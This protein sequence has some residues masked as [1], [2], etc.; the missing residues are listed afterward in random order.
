MAEAL[1]TSPGVLAI[2]LSSRVGSVALRD[3]AGHV[4]ERRFGQGD[5]TRE[6][7][8]PEIDR[9][10][11]D[12]G[13]GPGDLRAI[14]VSVGPGGFTGLR[15]AIAAA[16]GIATALDLPVVAVPSTLVIAESTRRA[17]R[18]PIERASALLVTVA[19]KRG[20]A[21]IHRLVRDDR[22][23]TGWRELAPP[24]TISADAIGNDPAWHDLGGSLVL[25]DE[26][27][28][29]LLIEAMLA[30]GAS[31]WTGDSPTPPIGASA[32]LAITERLLAARGA[33]APEAL[34]PIYPREPEAVT[35]WNLRHPEPTGRSG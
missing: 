35:L 3:R 29:P 5:R 1:D 8:L 11:R 16:K 9:L 21:W 31:R 17:T 4:A 2:E 20:T 22:D 10:V 18:A 13:M 33:I 14:G 12:A 7:L 24:G 6:P 15:I 23:A 26:H 25:A 27:Q 19:S 30:R 32:C 34:L 28:D